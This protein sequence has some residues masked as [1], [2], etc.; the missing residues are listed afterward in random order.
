MIIMTTAKGVLVKS[1]KE[2]EVKHKILFKEI[3]DTVQLLETSAT[4][5]VQSEV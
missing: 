4:I 3:D 5:R 1:D 2:F